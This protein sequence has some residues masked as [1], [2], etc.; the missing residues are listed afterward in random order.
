MVWCVY[1]IFTCQQN[2]FKRESPEPI[3]HLIAHQGQPTSKIYR[4]SQHMS[5]F[6]S[7]QTV[8]E[9]IHQQQQRLCQALLTAGSDLWAGSAPS[10]GFVETL[11]HQG[12]LRDPLVA[13]PTLPAGLCRALPSPAMA[14]PV[15]Q[16]CPS[17]SKCWNG[18][19][20]TL[21]FSPGLAQ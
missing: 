2:I 7:F 6:G 21:V 9:L 4:G 3:T 8:P 10:P 20:I 18:Q 17:H 13:Q 5:Y 16:P 19:K 1:S 12:H 14:R 15:F 11:S